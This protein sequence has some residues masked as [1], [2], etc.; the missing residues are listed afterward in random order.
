MRIFLFFF[1]FAIICSCSNSS[2]AVNLEDEQEVCNA[3]IG[4]WETT[5]LETSNSRIE[6]P[7]EVISIV[8]YAADGSF[9]TKK[10]DGIMTTTGKWSYDPMTH[11]INK[12]TKDYSYGVR[13]VRLTG[14]KL[15]LAGYTK[16]NDQVVDSNISTFRKF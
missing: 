8:S 1:V 4:S 14:R 6:V 9:E 16:I 13:I 2:S 7:K 10:K 15:N 5:H 11:N 12:S 3:L